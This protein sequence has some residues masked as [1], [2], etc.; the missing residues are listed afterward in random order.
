MLHYLMVVFITV[1]Q[2]SMS[3]TSARP[4]RAYRSELRQQ[5]A[6]QTRQR[7]LAAAAELFAEQGYA[8][9]TLA[10]IA[11]AAGVSPETVQ[12][13]GP[14]GALLT[15]AVEYA[16]FGI[17]GEE[18]IRN[19]EVGR[20]FSASKTSDEALGY[21]IDALTKVHLGTARIA[22][23]L[24]GA[25]SH[26]PEVDRFLNDLNASINQ[27]IRR[28]LDVALGRGWLR[29]DLPFDELVETTAVICSVDTYLRLTRD[30][31]TAARYR[32]WC[33][34]MMAENIFASNE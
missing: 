6:Q 19:L 26:D 25:A 28:I 11:E 27:Q 12:G 2:E 3:K 10:K 33:R 20:L 32:Q 16:A 30:G 4:A 7:I 23:A 14:K 24:I 17:A 21:L 34:R 9:T 22:P 1:P 13:H 15:A 31:W 5:Q 18:D 29:T 8:R